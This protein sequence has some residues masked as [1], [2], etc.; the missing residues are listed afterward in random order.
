MEILTNYRNLQC[1]YMASLREDNKESNLMVVPIFCIEQRKLFSIA[2][3]TKDVVAGMELVRPCASKISMMGLCK[4]SYWEARFETED[5]FDWYCEYAHIRNVLASY[6]SKTAR[7]LIAGT[8]TSRL[9]AEM[10]L[11]GY[12][13]VVAMDYAANVITKMQTRSKENAWGVRFA[14]ADLTQMKDWDSNCVDCVID[15]GCLDAM[16]L[17]PETDGGETSWKQVASDSSDDLSD[18]RNSMQQLARIL[19]PDGLLVLL[20]FGS[21]GNRVGLFDWVASDRSDYMEWEILQCLEMT[22]STSQ[23]TFA[24]RFFLFVARKKHK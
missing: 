18:A 23:P 24:T 22:P 8:G 19:K 6:I 15:K 21:P 3:T 5:E 9:P 10:A 7:V 14:E 1:F 12:S 16:L 13:D 20:T 2:W 11:D 17:K 4:K